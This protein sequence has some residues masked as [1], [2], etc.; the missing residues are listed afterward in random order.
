MT[1][2]I[3]LIIGILAVVGVAIFLIW[4]S[5]T[6]ENGGT[7]KVGFSIR[8]FFS[9]G[10]NTETNTEINT[11]ETDENQNE[12]QQNIVTDVS[13]PRLR[14]IS[15]EPIAGAVIFN[16]GTTSVVRF[17]EKGTGNVYEARSDK[18]SIERLTNTT[19]PK[20]I[21]AFWLPNGS[22]FL[23]QTLMENS[24]IIETSFVKLK[25]NPASSTVE[26]LTPFSTTIGK[27]PTGIKEIS[28]KPDGSKIFYYTT[29][30]P[31]NWYIANPDG[32]GGSLVATNY[33][34]EWIPFWTSADTV[35]MQNKSSSKTISN[36]Y[37]F[38]IKNKTLKKVPSVEFYGLSFNPN[39]NETLSLASNGGSQPTLFLVDSKNSVVSNLDVN[40]FAEKCVWLKEKNPTV[41]CAIPERITKSDYP[42]SWYKGL[43]SNQDL[44]TKI[45]V[46]N[47]IFYNIIYLSKE[48]GEKIDVVDMTLSPDES[49]LI[50][51]N[52]IDSY[53]WM[54][55]IGE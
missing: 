16:E 34:T 23:A 41:Y 11:E 31:S 5:T 19:I 3:L 26:D 7:N 45:E 18:T 29:P 4:N 20:I 17:V 9:F 39:S 6:Q 47:D 14:K 33:L 25:K 38:S 15:S 46:N 53:L 32:T 49:H 51:K 10:N 30:G 48:S 35:Y 21:R 12:E 54:L 43:V 27:L 22:G 1:K 44:I 52:K 24:E 36:V 55:R 13:V 40:T 2:K 37:S 28:I 50:F 42:D 8:E